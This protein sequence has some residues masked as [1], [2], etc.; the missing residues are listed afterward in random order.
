MTDAIK[1]ADDLFNVLR[2]LGSTPDVIAEEL[3]AADV[4]GV[5]EDPN[6]CPIANYLRRCTHAVPHVEREL[7]SLAWED[8]RELEARNPA[9]IR[10]FV[11]AFDSHEYPELDES[12]EVGA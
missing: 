4:T 2:D 12:E 8:G 6:C 10:L 7:T 9:P 11:A 5:R 3:L 1:T